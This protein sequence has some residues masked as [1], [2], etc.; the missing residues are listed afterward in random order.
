VNVAGEGKSKDVLV[1]G[2]SRPR[3]RLFD[4]VA[5]ADHDHVAD[6]VNVNDHVHVNV[7]ID[8]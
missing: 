3:S 4:H 8:S 6:A 5:V 7:I 1:L 2:R